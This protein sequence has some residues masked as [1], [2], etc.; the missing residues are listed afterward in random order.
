M[1]KKCKKPGLFALNFSMLLIGLNS[2]SAEVEPPVKEQ[3]C[4]EDSRSESI[5]FL[6]G[7][8]FK[9]MK[10]EG[11][12]ATAREPDKAV[13]S[14][15]LLSNGC[16][17]LKDLN[18]FVD[19]I[20]SNLIAV[21]SSVSTRKHHPNDFASPK[22]DAMLASKISLSVNELGQINEKM[23]EFCEVY[24]SRLELISAKKEFDELAHEFTD[25]LR[26]AYHWIYLTLKLPRPS[27]NVECNASGESQSKNS[28]T[29]GTSD[30]VARASSKAR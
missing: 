12:I 6:N 28:E 11:L 10:A 25:E 4:S 14:P 1:L 27:R 24:E 17:T 29:N 18:R 23:K 19:D 13:F 3:E 5:G 2:F 16:E 26:K 8:N 21:S 15:V 9:I 22:T 20:R 30:T 7:V